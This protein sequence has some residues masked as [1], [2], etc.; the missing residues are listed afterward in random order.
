MSCH[1][2]A[3]F[4]LMIMPKLTYSRAHGVQCPLADYAVL[5]DAMFCLQDRRLPAVLPGPMLALQVA[6]FFVSRRTQGL[7][8]RV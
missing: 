5:S 7:G 6:H 1:A 3:C 2:E 8:F 4:L